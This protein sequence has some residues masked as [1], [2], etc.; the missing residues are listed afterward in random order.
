MA[1][2]AKAHDRDNLGRILALA[3]QQTSQ[4][5]EQNVRNPN[6]LIACTIRRATAGDVATLQTI[7]H[8]AARRYASY[9]DTRFCLALPNRG[10]DEH[11]RV[12]DDGL[13]LLAEAAGEPIGFILVLP[14][15]GRAHILEL[16]VTLDQQ[17][18]GYGRA[19]ITAA[20]EWAASKG[21]HE[22]TLT[23]FRDVDWNA[24]FYAR[25]GYDPFDVGPDRLELGALI[26]DEIAAGVHSAPRVAMRK[27]LPAGL[28]LNAT[29]VIRQERASEFPQIRQ[30]IQK[31][32]AT[33][34]YAE[35]D[36]QDFVERLRQ[37]ES[38][39]PEQALILEDEGRLIA[40]VMLT[41]MSIDTAAGPYPILLLACVAVAA[42]YRN[43]GIG[44][45]L[46]EAALRRARDDGHRVVILVGDPAYYARLSFLPSI[47]FGVTNANGIE[48]EY[49]QLRELVPRAAR[50]VAGR[51]DLPS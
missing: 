51:V 45:A 46:I 1:W 39:L 47:Q 33:A 21:F 9:D 43:R 50:D 7:E 17:G 28:G 22:M 48:P 12:R 24:P 14:I 23:T 42:E 35:G 8:D 3:D 5:R 36:E 49:V 29:H 27:I 37:S 11:A 26:A 20:E 32:F 31:A 13:A 34:R 2:R 4:L 15:D 30:L 16:A 38:Y 44:T 10:D 40:H 19:L 6:A 41:R 18:H 25:L